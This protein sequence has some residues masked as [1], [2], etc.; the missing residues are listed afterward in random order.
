MRAF[1]PIRGRSQTGGA[2]DAAALTRDKPSVMDSVGEHGCC[3]LERLTGARHSSKFSLSLV[4]LAAPHEEGM[5]GRPREHQLGPVSLARSADTLGEK[6]GLW[7]TKLAP[8]VRSYARLV[9]FARQAS[10]SG[11]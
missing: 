8:S 7:L 5:R 1:P 6:Y 9:F 10:F 2:R 3:S 11:G 4:A